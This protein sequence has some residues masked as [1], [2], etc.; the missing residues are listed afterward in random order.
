MSKKEPSILSAI[1]TGALI[2]LF[3][4]YAFIPFMFVIMIIAIILMIPVAPDSAL[5]LAVI[6][7]YALKAYIKHIRAKQLQRQQILEQQ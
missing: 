6:V 7:G 5:F 3:L 2:G 1:A 4:R